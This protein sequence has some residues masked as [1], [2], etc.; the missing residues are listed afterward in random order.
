MT[1]TSDA[2]DELEVYVINLDRRVDRIRRISECLNAAGLRFSRVRAVDGSL[3]LGS[4]QRNSFLSNASVAN[5]MSH[6]VA[7]HNLVGSRANFALIL[8][9]DADLRNF[10]LTPSILVKWLTLMEEKDLELLQVG[11]ISNIYGKFTPRAILD[12]TLAQRSARS[13]RDKKLKIKYISNEFRAGTHAYIIRKDLAKHLLQANSPAF[14]AADAYF[15]AIV[16]NCPHPRFARL[17]KSAIEQESR[18][19]SGGAIDSDI[20]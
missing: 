20:Q 3:D 6:Q 18:L 5:W 4:E 1:T 16:R 19:A 13:L 14:L 11:Y 17:A 15:E 2:V 10:S 8:E 12:W 7:F 9:D